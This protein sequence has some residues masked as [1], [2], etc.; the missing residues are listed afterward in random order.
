M[1]SENGITIT[2]EGEIDISREFELER[3][4]QPA[5]WADRA[6]L[7]FSNVSFASTTLINAVVR[8]HNHMRK[9]GRAGII[10]IVGCKPHIKRVLTL[11]RLDTVFEI[12]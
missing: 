2:L 12:R 8:L 11:A 7:D 9:H 10:R 1:V 4:L 5:Q 6:T 3:T